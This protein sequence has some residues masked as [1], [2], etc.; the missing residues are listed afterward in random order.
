VQT[1]SRASGTASFPGVL[2]GFSRGEDVDD[3]HAAGV[4]LRTDQAGAGP[5]ITAG[6]AT[7]Q[8]PE[9][10]GQ[11]VHPVG[12]GKRLRQGIFIKIKPPIAQWKAKLTA[13]VF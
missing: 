2:S 13:K 12:P 3:L 4:H 6:A 1:T 5:R 9:V 7:K 8:R 10:L 11:G